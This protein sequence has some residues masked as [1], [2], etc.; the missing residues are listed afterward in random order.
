MPEERLCVAHVGDVFEVPGAKVHI[1]M[2]YD[3]TAIRT[4]GGK[5]LLPFEECCCSFLF[6]TSAGNIMFLGDTWYHDGYVK[7]GKEYDIAALWQPARTMA[8]ATSWNMQKS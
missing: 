1:L 2:C 8:S 5:E 7:I 3:E 6:E 4:G